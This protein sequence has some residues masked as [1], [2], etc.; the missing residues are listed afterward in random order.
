MS[1]F[2][3]LHR[4]LSLELGIEHPI[5]V[6]VISMLQ[7]IYTDMDSLSNS[8]EFYYSLALYRCLIMIDKYISAPEKNYSEILHFLKA[9]SGLF[10]D[11]YVFGLLNMVLSLCSGTFLEISSVFIFFRSICSCIYDF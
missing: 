2:L 4:Y 11:K 3:H 5:N 8:D 6:N 1:L 10:D 9:I 7:E